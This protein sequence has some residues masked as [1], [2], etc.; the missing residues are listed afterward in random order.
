MTDTFGH[1]LMIFIKCFGIGAGAASALACILFALL[2]L[3]NERRA[4]K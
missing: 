4:K 1:Y 3:A 2:W